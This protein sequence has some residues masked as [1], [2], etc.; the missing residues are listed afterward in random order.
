M[1]LWQDHDTEVSSRLYELEGRRVH[2]DLA[3]VLPRLRPAHRLQHQQ[4]LTL[5][6]HLGALKVYLDTICVEN[7]SL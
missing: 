5:P 2:G 6:Y 3:L 7:H 1:S 4:V